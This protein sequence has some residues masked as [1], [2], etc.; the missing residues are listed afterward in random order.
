MPERPPTKSSKPGVQNVFWTSTTTSAIRNR[1]VAAGPERVLRAPACRVLEPR[2]VV[3]APHLADPLGC[4]VGRQRERRD[5]GASVAACSRRSS[6]EL[7]RSP[8]GAA[9]RSRA[10][11]RP[12]DCSRCSRPS[13]AARASARSARAVG[14]APPGSSPRSRPRRRSSPSSSTPSALPPR[15]SCSPT[16]ST[17][18]SSRATGPT[19]LPAEAPFD[20]LFADGGGQAMK[21]NPARS[22]PARAG[23]DARAGQP[24]AR[25]P[26]PRSRPRALA[27]PPTPR[28]DRAP[29]L[30]AR[31]GDRR[32]SSS[33]L[34]GCR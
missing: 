2:R 5:H 31:S 12:A 33:F 1:S 4:P 7:S 22:R 29:A 20:L 32:S 18:A 17:P 13:A 34:G 26:R 15:P 8:S 23:R 14:S 30:S 9:S 27:P 11:T 28:R 3:D 25:S 21:T 6:S 16:T 10:A 19:I 24:H